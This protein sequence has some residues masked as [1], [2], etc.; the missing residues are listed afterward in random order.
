MRKLL[1]IIA[2]LCA[3]TLLWAQNFMIT[4]TA[5]EKL[6]EVTGN[7]ISG[8]HTEAF[9]THISAHSFSHGKGNITFYKKVTSIGN[10]AFWNCYALSSIILPNSVTSIGDGCFAHCTSLTSITLP[11]SV[12]SIGEGAFA[13][14]DR[15]T[16]YVQPESFNRFSA[17]ERLKGIKITTDSAKLKGTPMSVAPSSNSPSTASPIYA[18]DIIDTD[19]PTSATKN[20]RTFAV[21]I[22]NENYQMVAGVP[23]A[24]N[25]A[26]IF[27]QYCQK[28]LGLPEHNV[29]LYTDA[30]YGKMRSAIKDIKSIAAAFTGDISVVFYY[31]GH[32]V[33]NES[34]K[35]AFLL[36]IDADGTDTEVCMS[37]DYLYK[38]LASLQ[39]N[40]VVVFLDACFSGSK[41]E[42]G[43]LA[44]ARGIAIKAKSGV[45]QGN[46]VVFS[47][48]QGDETAYPNKEKGHGM[49]TYYLLK[50]LQDT[51]GDVTLQDLG[52]YITKN[53]SQQ[54]I[55]INGKSQ[56]PSVTASSTLG[57]TWQN[58]KLK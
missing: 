1:T 7:T 38:E 4:Y 45:P 58:W 57:D 28:T 29:R 18:P 41:R 51:K 9:N 20:N 42:D 10:Y 11:N 40:H 37:L 17:M 3:A 16:I 26:K 35:D 2:L 54:S 52:N 8:L 30:T 44:S 33:P 19:I 14:C 49:F 12:T 48:A 50:K 15:L 23:Y 24:T 27:A 55:L 21:I 43:M 34:S 13:G 36:P 25:D 22:G 53:V 56:T 6:M 32:G 5:S 39:A 46:M 47:A 31:A